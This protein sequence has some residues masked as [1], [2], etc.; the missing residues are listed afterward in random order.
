MVRVK[1]IVKE[2][3]TVEVEFRVP[4]PLSEIMT[5]KARVNMRDTMTL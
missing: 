3:V 4:I 2:K 1:K 5:K